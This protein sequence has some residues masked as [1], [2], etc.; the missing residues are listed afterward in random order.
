[1]SEK[2]YE[3]DAGDLSLD[4]ANTADWHA[5]NHPQERLDGLVDVIQ[6]GQQAGLLTPEA[7]KRLLQSVVDKPAEITRFHRQTIEVREAIYRIFSHR[8]TGKPI[9]KGDLTLLNSL[10]RKAMAHRQLVQSGDE[11]HWTWS[12]EVDGINLILWPVAFAAAHL[13]ASPTIS[14][15]RECEDD[16]GCGFLFVDQT[17]NHSRRWCSMESCGNR[18]KARRHYSRIQA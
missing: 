11:F 3:F 12:P 14:R 18:A 9:R 13:L 6:W 8:Y 7:A 2:K 4:F 15:V 5:S 1:M 16:R 10:V 17:K